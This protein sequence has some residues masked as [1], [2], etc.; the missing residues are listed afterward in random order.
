M[1]KIKP[2]LVRS[3]GKAHRADDDYKTAQKNEAT[4][5]TNPCF[6]EQLKTSVR[7]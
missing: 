2:I 6:V 1:K 7:F 4:C 3:F 5:R